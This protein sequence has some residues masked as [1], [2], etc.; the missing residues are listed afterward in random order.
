VLVQLGTVLSLI[1]Y[2]WRD[3][4]ALIRAFF[5]RPFSTPENRLAWYIIIATIPALAAGV[6]LRDVVQAL[7][8][9]PLLEAAIRLWAA[10]ALM[11]AA[12]YFGK[13]SRGL[14]AMTWL[15]ALV[16][17]LFQVLAVF[18]GASRSGSTIS[19]G[20]FRGFDRP[21]A[22]RFAFLIS[23][24]VLLAAGAY[25]MVGV[26]GL[27]DLSSFLPALLVG[28][29]TAAVVGWFA[30]RW[31]LAYLNRGSLYVFAAYCA[32]VGALCLIGFAL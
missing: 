22:A 5:A 9:T 2:F 3:L 6:L 11:A 8:E 17:G 1:V 13:R 18:P 31:L 12:E 27:P 10:A 16:V 20:M 30:I 32:V 21:S 14:E 23:V 25:E 26:M 4:L 24:P 19:G 28:F 7:F 29:A 15:D